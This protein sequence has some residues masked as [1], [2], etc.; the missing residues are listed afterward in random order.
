MELES[1]FKSSSRKSLF[2]HECYFDLYLLL[3]FN[4]L[5]RSVFHLFLAVI[6]GKRKGDV[7]AARA[8]VFTTIEMHRDRQPPTHFFCIPL[9]NPELNPV[10]DEFQRNVLKL[11]VFSSLFRILPVSFTI[12]YFF[13]FFNSKYIFTVC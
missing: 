12:F 5:L 7:L 2:F 4:C 6:T 11:Q 13:L 8:K 10:F 9:E 3:C 1:F